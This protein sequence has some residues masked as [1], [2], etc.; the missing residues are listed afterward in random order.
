MHNENLYPMIREELLKQLNGY[1]AKDEI[2]KDIDNYV[3][4][5]SLND[6]QGIIG[7]CE[8]GRLKLINE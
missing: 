4:K 6:N 3:V 2:L 7:A 8:L 1:I 5:P